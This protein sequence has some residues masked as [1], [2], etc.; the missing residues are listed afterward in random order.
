MKFRKLAVALSTALVLSVTGVSVAATPAQAVTQDPVVIVAGTFAGQSVA[1]IFYAPLAARIR[2]DGRQAYIFGLPQSG[3][4]DARNAAAQLNSF[5]DSVR[6]VTGSAKVD[7]IGHSQGGMVS[8]YYIKNLGGQYEVD[9]LVSLGAVHYGTSLANLAKLLG[10]GSCLGIIGCEQM[11]IGSSFLNSLNYGDDTI[12]NV[13]YT[14]IVTSMDEVILPYTNGYLNND[15]NNVNTN[16][17][18]KC[19]ARI[20][21]HITLATDG[22]VYSGIRQALNKQTINYNCWAL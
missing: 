15:G 6:A 13:M 3:L 8:R 5:V 18:S 1:S 14:N 19:W 12:G 11:A 21:G 16:V 4:G 20:V 17:R 9:S 10:L 7:L 2:A 22:A